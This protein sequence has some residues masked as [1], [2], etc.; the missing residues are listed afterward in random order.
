[1]HRASVLRS[2]C[3]SSARAFH[4]STTSSVPSAAAAPATSPS[5]SSEPSPSSPSPPPASL[6]YLP[7]PPAA[8]QELFRQGILPSPD[9]IVNP[10]PRVR[11]IYAELMALSQ[12]EMLQLQTV[13]QKSYGLSVQVRSGWGLG[14][15]AAVFSDGPAPSGP[16]ASAAAAP[17]APSAGGLGEK[18]EAAPAQ[19]SFTVRLDS[20]A[21]ADKIKIIKEVRTATG[22]GLK[23]SKELVEAAPK[24]VKKDLSKADCD[25]LVA[26]LKEAG[27]KVTVE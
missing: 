19:A 23:E 20:F 26:K 25:A 10:T 4:S 21:A 15:S 11:E 27:A 1:M 9:V 7:A 8:H 13:L 2:C 12:F 18:K 24:V 17:S 3:A 6:P 14:A 16:S 22:L 5:P